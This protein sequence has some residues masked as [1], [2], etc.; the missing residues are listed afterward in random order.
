MNLICDH[1]K[2]IVIKREQAKGIFKFNSDEGYVKFKFQFVKKTIASFS[3]LNK[4]LT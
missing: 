4:Q 2:S 1:N 3:K